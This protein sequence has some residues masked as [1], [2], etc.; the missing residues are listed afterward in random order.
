MLRMRIV[1]GLLAAILVICASIVSLGRVL[2]QQDPGAGNAN[3]AMFFPLVVNGNGS[4]ATPI[5]SPTATGAATPTATST[6]TA[7]PTATATA[8]PSPTGTQLPP[9]PGAVAPPLDQTRSTPLLDAVDFLFTGD[10]PIQKGVSPGTIQIDRV[11]VLRGKV[12]TR[13]GAALPAVQ[14]TVLG[15]PE[16]GRTLSRAD[17]MF[18]LAVNGGGPL[19]VRYQAAGF[20]AVQRAVDAPWR[21]YAWLPD[22]VMIP[23][24][25]VVTAVDLGAAN[26][27]VARGS[28]V[29]DSDGTRQATLLIPQGTT[30]TLVLADGTTSPLTAIHVRATEFTA[31]APGPAAMPGELPPSSGYTYAAELSIDEASAVGATDVRFN[32]PL[33]VY[34]ENFLGFPVGGAVPAGYYDRQLG[35]WVAAANGRVIKVLSITNGQANL[36][37]AGNDVAADATA[38]AA[39]GIT[40]EERARLAQLYAPGQTLWRVP[41]SH[42]TPWDCNWPYGPPSD[43]IPPP[44]PDGNN[45]HTAPNNPDKPDKDCSSVIGCE[46]LTLGE[47]LPIAGTPWR[48]FYQSDR[49]PGRAEASTL[50]IP[51]SGATIP[52]SLRS[53][54]VEVSVAGRLFQQTFAPAPNR[55]YTLVW[56]G[57]DGYGRHVQGTQYAT[58]RVRYDYPLQYYAS[59]AEFNNSFG[60]AEAAGALVSRGRGPGLATLTTEWLA[61]VESPDARSAGLGGWT[62]SI[63]HTYDPTAQMLILGDGQRRRAEHLPTAIKTVAGSWASSFSGDGGPATAAGMRPIGAD[64]A[65]DG[66]LYFADYEYNRIRRVGTDGVITGVVGYGFDGDGGPALTASI[67]NPTDVAFGP[68]GSLY[69]TDGFIKVRRVGPDGIIS[70]V[71]GGVSSTP[72]GDGGPATAAGLRADNLAVG[73]DGSLYLGDYVHN[74]VR[75]VATDGIITTIAGGDAQGFTGDGGPATAASLSAPRGLAVGPDGSLYIADWGNSRIRRVGRDGIITTV[76]GTG[77]PYFSGDGG[78]AL[79]A[80]ISPYG[81][82]VDRDGVVYFTE[83]NGNRVRRIGQ[84]GIITTIAGIGDLGFTGDGGPAAAARLKNPSDIAIDPKGNLYITDFGNYRIRRMR[85]PVPDLAAERFTLPSEDGT[86]AYLFDGTGRHLSTLDGVTGA[87]RY[88]FGYSADGYLTTVTD[89]FGNVTKIERAGA[90]PTAIVA[91]G[92]QRTTFTVDANGWL[93]SVAN[94]AGEQYT[95][96]Y[97]AAGLLQQFVD[98]RTDVHTFSYDGLGRLVTDANP[99]GGSL[100]LHRVGGDRVYTVTTSSALGLSRARQVAVLP[101][102][103]VQRATIEP[104]GAR[105]SMLINPDGSLKTSYANGNVST[106]QFGPDPRWGMLAPVALAETMRTPGGVTA[107]IQTQ[108]D[109]SLAVPDDVTSL[110]AMTATTNFNGQSYREVYAGSNRTDTATSPAGRVL[111]RQFTPA[112]LLAMIRRAPGIAPLQ[113]TYDAAGRLAQLSHGAL[114]ITLTRDQLGRVIQIAD[115]SG[116]GVHFTYD[117][118]DR[119]ISYTLPSGRAYSYAYDAAGNR[120]RVVM[121]SGAQHQMTYTPV[122]RLATYTPPGGSSYALAYD[123]DGHLAAVTVPSGGVLTYGSDAFGRLAG[124]TFPGVK[125]GYGYANSDTLNAITRGPQNGAPTQSL[126]LTRDGTLLTQVTVVGMGAD[127]VNY[128]YNNDFRLTSATLTSGA[129]TLTTAYQRDADGL[130]TGYGPFTIIRNGPAGGA[131]AIGDGTLALAITYDGSGR[132]I[133]RSYKVAGQPAA[134]LTL[135]FDAQSRVISRTLTIGGAS[136][137][138]AYAYNADSQLLAVAYD[139]VEKERYAYDVNGNRSSRRTVGV[140]TQTATFN[141]ADRIL[142]QGGVQYQVNPDG[143]VTQRGADTFQYDVRGELTAATVNGKA[144]TYTYD[145]LGRRVARS[146]A[147]GVTQYLYDGPSSLLP[148]AVRTPDG[149]LTHYYYDDLGLL[150][151][152]QQGASRYYVVTD[153]TG[154]PLFVVDPAG[155]AVK[156]VQYDSYGVLLSDTNPAFPV[157]IGFG[158]GLADPVTGLVRLGVRDYD[159]GTGRWTALDPGLFDADPLNLYA[160]VSSDPVSQRDPTG[161]FSVSANGYIGI[162]AGF[163][164]G[165]DGKG[166]SFC[167]EAGFGIGADLDLSPIGGIDKDFGGRTF[168][169][170]F[171]MLGFGYGIERN[172]PAEF[173]DPCINWDRAQDTWKAKVP[174]LEFDTGTGKVDPTIKGPDLHGLGTGLEVKVASKEC[175]AHLW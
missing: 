127:Q 16:Y 85:P 88:S 152:L 98:P 167:A 13:E 21:D 65:P 89:G 165:I 70:T 110:R 86:E 14:I 7:T 2:A 141:A 87:L 153:L 155:A 130:V 93:A 52:P 62:L 112:G 43:A 150:F 147:N 107:Q 78:P 34:V 91:P 63:Q 154:T 129:D 174:F 151:A 172:V 66:S 136:Q 162:G 64:V 79:A 175:I 26:L 163:K 49:V 124:L 102:D 105:R 47:S 119:L 57:K 1:L 115:G 51:V 81:I 38:L 60:R 106:V 73:P 25:P 101:T 30:A 33:P 139:G 40:P 158:G 108:W 145:G 35:H 149:K 55:T 24:D 23:L 29:T 6:A 18:D 71:A 74:R 125:I 99:A 122:N 58:V 138:R 83:Y 132:I 134:S 56:D 32:Q 46:D 69:L 44:K 75:R 169:V 84:D 50:V 94:P 148:T 173:I 97:T 53:M 95:M 146:D 3:F 123:K 133:G 41:I 100:T 36:D 5:P 120:T 59:R 118:A 61:L 12:L 10:N 72:S 160:Y 39:L 19:T 131:S 111:L 171:E 20:L 104:S 92:G 117:A 11:A 68:D 116:P 54:S 126:S 159:P 140:A 42:F 45:P 9:D 109:A 28:V 31:G 37:I 161:L 114:T 76:A 96:A 15:H 135:G 170:N 113:F 137:T 142:T 27:Q 90:T 168:E 22:V 80:G 156:T 82:A 77:Q 48:L 17:G 166:I 103:V 143:Y 144:V 128:T 8:T 157:A 67:G 121:P 4:A 164:L